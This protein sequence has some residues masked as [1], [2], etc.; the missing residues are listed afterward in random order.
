MM[1]KIIVGLVFSILCTYCFSAEETQEL[2]DTVVE[3]KKGDAQ[4]Q[5]K[6]GLS[7]QQGDANAQYELGM[8][9]QYGYGVPVNKSQ[10][11]DWYI[12]SSSGGN[13]LAKITLSMMYL[14]GDGVA[15][16]YAE[17][18]R[19]S[20]ET[21]ED[22]ANQGD[23]VAEFQLAEQYYNSPEL[24]FKND[25][26][27]AA[28][29][30]LKS[31]NQ[32]FADAQTMLGVM[33]AKGIGLPK[34]LAEAISWYRKAAMQGNKHAQRNLGMLYSDGN[35]IPQDYVAAYVLLNKSVFLF[36]QLQRD[37]VGDTGKRL[38]EIV[39]KMTPEQ[40]TKAKMINASWKV[41]QPFPF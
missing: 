28:D 7:A 19:L 41:G 1:R 15:Q 4:A 2:K 11:V 13:V 26:K 24:L 14:M 16:D 39:Q 10:A 36:G 20:R 32:G 29:W 22:S 21:F 5:V 37:E 17:Y 38:D 18:R 9:N 31:A 33:Y 12:K 40:L 35:T 6:L 3:A 8:M 34:N 23:R 25:Y 30:Y 27:K